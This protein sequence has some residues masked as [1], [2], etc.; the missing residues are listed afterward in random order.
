VLFNSY[1]FLLAFL[2][3]T[4]LGFFG[5]ARLGPTAA[6]AWLV[7]ASLA[8]Y[9]WWNPIYVLLLLASIAFNYAMGG[10]IGT[11]AL[12]DRSTSKLLL[13]LAV[14][15]D[16]G[17]L[18]Y[19]KYANFFV[20]TLA[21]L[22]GFPLEVARVVLPLGISF[23]TF[24]QIAFLVDTYRGKASER[25][26]VHYALFVTYFPHLIAGPILHHAEMMP[27][28]RD[29]NVYRAT[30]DN[31]AVGLTIFAIGLFKKVVL[32]DG[33]APFASSVFANASV[34]PPGFFDAWGG[35]LVYTLQLYFDFS[36]YCDMAIGLSRLFGIQLPINFDS[37]YKATNI[38]DFWRRWHITLS[39][40]LR[41]YVYI[42]LGGNRFG[43]TRRYANLLAT[44]LIGG[45]WHGAGWTFVAWGGL[46]GAYLVV[47]HAW[48]HLTGARE[49]E[50]GTWAGRNLARLV[51]FVAVVFAWVLFRAPDFHTATTI[52]EGMIGQNGVSMPNAIAVHFPVLARRLGSLGVQFTLGGG[53]EFVRMY[54]WIAVLLP[55][56]FVA[57]N[58]QEM[59]GGYRPGIGAPHAP[60]VRWAAWRPSGPWALACGCVA[61]IG[62]LSLHR[63]SEFLYY[64][65]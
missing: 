58:T 14:A 44:M 40:F 25:N 45:L 53:S 59:L 29:R 51:T 28:F 4:L 1:P 10:W 41:D 35:A 9:A 38:I 3:V 47:N 11:A 37:P 13:T 65:F 49:G 64:Q 63:V 27:Q 55:L 56:V 32:A 6:A 34:S 61:A 48:R 62:F 46:H 43:K 20:D 50:A 52:I 5:L 16:L 12:R 23:Y 8:F 36:G 19:Y 24:T 2:P 17:V 33:I 7:V 21:S 39:R 60:P 57:P 30:A 18:G 22:S 26:P 31:F 42:P 15:V 54:A